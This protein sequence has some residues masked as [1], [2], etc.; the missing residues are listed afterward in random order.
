M[1]LFEAAE[2]TEL[3][4]LPEIRQILRRRRARVLARAWEVQGDF[5]E[6]AGVLLKAT[7]GHWAECVSD[8]D[9]MPFWIYARDR[10]AYLYR[11]TRRVHGEFQNS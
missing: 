3:G 11:A 7:D 4:L 6:A 9:G 10:L 5:Q 8:P 1:R 2:R